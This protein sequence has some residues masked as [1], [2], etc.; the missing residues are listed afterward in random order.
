[1]RAQSIGPYCPTICDRRHLSTKNRSDAPPARQQGITSRLF[2][3]FNFLTLRG[4]GDA[5]SIEGGCLW[6]WGIAAAAQGNGSPFLGCG[7]SII[8]G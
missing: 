4:I 6:T 5:V 8:K 7:T 1:M 2:R 3:G